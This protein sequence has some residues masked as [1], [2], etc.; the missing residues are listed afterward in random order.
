MLCALTLARPSVLA[1]SPINNWMLLV[2]LKH[3]YSSFSR[4]EVPVMGPSWPCLDWELSDWI[5]WAIA[6]GNARET[7]AW[8]ALGWAWD[9]KATPETAGKVQ[10][11]WSWTDLTVVMCQHEA[12][13][14][15]VVEMGGNFVRQLLDTTWRQTKVGKGYVLVPNIRLLGARIAFTSARLNG[16][17][18]MSQGTVDVCM[19]AC[20]CVCKAFPDTA[21]PSLGLLNKLTLEVSCGLLFI[22]LLWDGW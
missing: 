20:V 14:P 1:L 3:Q 22:F 11:D 5:W 10:R 13:K 15:S 17:R 21:Y 19:D 9:R 2:F 12:I 18:G 8:G 6:N 16:A 4:G 7:W